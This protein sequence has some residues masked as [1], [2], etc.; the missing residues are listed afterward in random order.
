MPCCWLY[1]ADA[2]IMLSWL[3]CLDFWG[4]CCLLLFFLTLSIVPVALDKI[5][6]IYACWKCIMLWKLLLWYYTCSA[7]NELALSWTDY[8]CL[9]PGI[10]SVC[11]VLFAARKLNL[12]LRMLAARYACLWT[13]LARDLQTSIRRWLIFFKILRLI[14]WKPDSA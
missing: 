8:I 11:F 12:S 7:G 6:S 9:L 5:A 14:V 4:L 13:G 10:E 3:C 1:D 2:L